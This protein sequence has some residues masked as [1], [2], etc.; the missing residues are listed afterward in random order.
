M[1][2]NIAEPISGE[3][4]YQERARQALPLLARQAEAGNP[5]FY[6]DLAEEL[7]M[8]NPRNL[9]YVLGS[10]GQT[11]ENLSKA[12]KVSIPPIQCLVINKS[13]GLP[14]EGIGWSLIKKQEFS[15]LSRA[16]QREIV[17]GELARIYAYP[18]WSFVLRSLNLVPTNI[19]FAALNN[20]TAREG[21]GGGEG[22]RHRKLKE[23]V[24]ANPSVIDLSSKTKRGT[25]ECYLPSGDSLDVSFSNSAEWV[26]A[27]VKSSISS[28]TDIVRGLYQCVKYQAVMQAVEA[29]ENRPRNARAVLVLESK[30]PR[31]LVALKNILGVTVYDDIRLLS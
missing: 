21:V 19:S 29:S 18:K 30:I 9:N 24:A 7:G 8:P 2:A 10:I 25:V 1:T 20:A 16:K 14:G 17:N 22:E 26:A 5:I 13:T 11:M 27:E 15:K 6:S 23:F 4:L 12:W 31:Q 28:E 3:K